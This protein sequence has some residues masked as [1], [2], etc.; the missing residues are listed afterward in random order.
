MHAYLS[1]EATNLRILFFDGDAQ[2]FDGDGF[3]NEDGLVGINSQL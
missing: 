1:L 2:P 3:L